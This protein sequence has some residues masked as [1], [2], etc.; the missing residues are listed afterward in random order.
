MVVLFG[1]ELEEDAAGVLGVD[2]GLGPAVGALHAVERLDA[3]VADGLRRRFNVLD[4]EGDVVQPRP[5]L[6]QEADLLPGD[7]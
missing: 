5:P 3:V 7:L 1:V 4:L 2:I 6:L